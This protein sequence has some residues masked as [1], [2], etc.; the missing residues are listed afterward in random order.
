MKVQTFVAIAA[1]LSTASGYA[2]AQGAG[3]DVT[4]AACR[5][6]HADQFDSVAREPH[7]VIDSAAW[8][9][10]RNDSLSCTAC[11]GDVTEHV[12][13][14]GRGPVFAFSDESALA[15][16]EVC[17]SCHA[18]SHPRYAASE[19]SRAGLTCT[20]CHSVH[21]AELSASGLLKASAGAPL[22][23][24]PQSAV[25]ADCHQASFAEFELNERHRLETVGC[26]ACHD[27]HAPEARSLLGGFRQQACASCHL[28]TQGPFVFE[29]RASRVDGCAACHSPHGSPNR[30]LLTHQSTGE[31]C[32]TC[33]A[34][35]PQF[36]AGFAPVGPPRFGLDA[37]CTNCHVTIHGS[38]LDPDFLR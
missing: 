7:S 2:V 37:Q 3:S 15:Q 35:V 23:A 17:N 22:G 31:L 5:V 1:L 20:D 12:G 25:C 24:R 32:F 34:V 8:Q 30:H 13:A 29:H 11:H 36:H 18:D 21:S 33:H 27:S 4:T 9:E 38:N 19:H 6:C 14:G 16:T 10:H 28:D 26:S